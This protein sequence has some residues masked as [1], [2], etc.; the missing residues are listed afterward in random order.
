[1]LDKPHIICCITDALVERISDGDNLTVSQ[2]RDDCY[3]CAE[4]YQGKC[5]ANVIIDSDS[6]N[7]NKKMVDDPELGK[8]LSAKQLC[9]YMTT[10]DFR[11]EVY[12]LQCEGSYCK[13]ATVSGWVNSKLHEDLSGLHGN[14]INYAGSQHITTSENDDGFTIIIMRF[15]LEYYFSPVK[16][17][18]ST[19]CLR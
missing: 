17:W 10:L 2:N 9:V 13:A 6:T 4:L 5:A 3:D 16:P 1:M 14:K 15:Q 12:A 7:R 11:V 8:S 19:T 18:L